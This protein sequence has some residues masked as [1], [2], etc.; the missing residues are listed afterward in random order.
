M[1]PEA[2]CLVEGVPAALTGQAAV[3][4]EALPLALLE[5]A[6][7]LPVVEDV[8]GD[9][10]E[11]V[12]LVHGLLVPGLLPPHGGQVVV[13]AAGEEA[14]RRSAHGGGRGLT[15]GYL[16]WSGWVQVGQYFGRLTNY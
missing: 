8:G 9:E 10:P 16:A 6:P 4:G 5:A 1:K 2:R 7:Q 14:G 3:C 15:D 13:L 12:P 11:K